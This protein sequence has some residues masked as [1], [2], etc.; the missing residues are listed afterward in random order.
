MPRVRIDH[1]F[2]YAELTDLVAALAKE[3]PG[4]C[5]VESIGRSHE[6]RDIW[7]VTVTNRATG[8][9][10]DKPAF[11]VDGNIHSVEVAAS[12]ACLHFLQ[13]LLEHYG[14][15][16][17]VTRALDTRTFYLCP[18]INPDGAEWALAD[19]PKYVRSSTRSYPFEE[20]A[21]EGLTVED[22]DGN[23][24]I[25]QMR[26]RDANGLWKSHPEE[27]QL[28]VRRDPTEVGGTYYRILPE[29]RLEGY[30][31][32]NLR[33]KKPKQGLDLNRNFPGNWRQEFEQLGAGPY[34]TSEPEVRALADFIVR[35][36]NITGGVAFHTW[37]GVLLRPFDHLPDTDMHAEDLWHYQRVGAKGTELTGY[38]NISVYHEF[39]YHPKQVI[40][41]AFDWIYDH[42]GMFSWVVE[43]WC[44]MRE[45]GLERYQYIDW[46]RD[47]PIADDLKLFRWNQEKLGGAGHIAWK[48]FDHPELGPIEIG[49]WDRFHAFV[50]PP[51]QFLE[52]ELARF[53]Q[54]LLWQALLSPRLELVTAD[55]QGLG[56]GLWR[57]RLVVQNT[58]WLPSYVSK[59]ALERKVVR[60]VFAEI[61]MPQGVELVTGKRREEIGQ[62]E[63][64]AYKHTGISFW[65]DY[66]VTDDRAKIEWV[67]RGK[68][69][70]AINLVARHERAGT[71]R[72]VVVLK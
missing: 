71:V 49:G 8:A 20:D 41:G 27:P 33:V 6:G 46:Y 45:A 31:G 61:A 28:M 14:K 43:I 35:H 62:L 51:L 50:N 21:I 64:K 37:A 3:F 10:A 2:R 65:P 39:R 24:R 25:L 13:H 9:P 7:L 48:S 36:P 66:H 67:V 53:P 59:R 63:G 4:L 5:S 11:W 69:G 29:G 60:G 54:W 17:E 47:H 57:V 26:I 58:G 72:V 22:I 68:P 16:P 18:R 34:P 52:R 55:A 15:D 12:A 56:D 70:D 32:F 42:L 40:G 19:H 1:Y 38:P 44:P 23:G 30:D